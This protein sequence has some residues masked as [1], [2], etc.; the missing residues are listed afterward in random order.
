M[1]REEILA[2]ATECVCGQREIDYGKPENNFK[3]IA[4]FWNAYLYNEV[5]NLYKKVTAEDVAIMMALL[6]IA[7][8]KAG[9]NEDCYVDLAGYAACAGEIATKGMDKPYETV[10]KP[11]EW[12]GNS[13]NTNKTQNGS[14]SG[15]ITEWIERENVCKINN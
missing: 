12:V 14:N 6:K 8:I 9:G 13:S 2:K 1:N 15:S 10:H 11:L 7:R 3:E 5:E 4:R